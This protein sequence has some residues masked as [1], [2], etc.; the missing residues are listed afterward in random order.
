VSQPGQPAQQGSVALFNG[1][2]FHVTGVQVVSDGDEVSLYLTSTRHAFGS[3]SNPV[4][5][6][7]EI[8]ARLIMSP[9]AVTRVTETLKAYAEQSKQAGN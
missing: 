2:T 9:A 8:V 1:P 7:N 3:G 4:R 6:V 5:A